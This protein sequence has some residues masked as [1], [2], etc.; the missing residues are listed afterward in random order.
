MHGSR[1]CTSTDSKF[2]FYKQHRHVCRWITRLRIQEKHSLD[3]T[4]RPPSIFHWSFSISLSLSL[5]QRN[6]CALCIDGC[7][8]AIK[9]GSW[10]GKLSNDMNENWIAFERSLKTL[11]FD[12]RVKIRKIDIWL[13]TS[14][15]LRCMCTRDVISELCILTDGWTGS[16]V[17]SLDG[18]TVVFPCILSLANRFSECTP[19]EIHYLPR[20]NDQMDV[21]RSGV[22]L[23]FAEIRCVADRY[24]KQINARTVQYTDAESE[25]EYTTRNKNNLVQIIW[26]ELI[27]VE[28]FVIDNVRIDNMF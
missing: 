23:N 21:I 4:V 18:N 28:R 8:H 10:D 20:F 16:L 7:L 15:R 22:K 14:V 27:A 2:Y 25:F 11:Y 13:W 17:G 3:G 6:V 1:L 5:S 26:M 12:G 9:S 24:Y 19:L